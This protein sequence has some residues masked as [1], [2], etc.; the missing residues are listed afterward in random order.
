[1]AVALYARVSTVK[2]AEKDL[3]IPDQLNQMR[4]WCVANGHAV[5]MEYIEAGASATDD[6]RP[7]FQQMIADATADSEP[8]EAVII[9]SR[10]RFFREMFEFLN[11]ERMLKRAG[12]KI[13][14]ITQITSNDPAGEMAAKIFSLF[15]EYQSKE[16]GK[17]TLRAMKENARRGYFNG[18]RPPYGY[19]TIETELMGTKGKKKKRIEIDPAESTTVKRIY[20]LYLNGSEQ[21][22]MGAKD[23]ATYLNNKNLMMRAQKWNRSRVH[24]VLSSSTYKGEYYFNKTDQKTKL[25]KPKSEWIKLEIEPVISAATY[26]DA[27]SRRAARAPA[28]VPPRLVNSPTLLTGLLKCGICGAGLTTATGKGGRYRYYKCNTRIGKGVHLCTMPSFPM[29]KLDDLVLTSLADKVFTADRVQL[30]L[31]EMKKLHKASH[32]DQSQRL[33]PLQKE[34]ESLKLSSER[35]FEAVEKGYL[36]MDETLQQRSHKLQARR[37]DVLLEIA[38]L[39]RQREMPTDLLQPQHIKAF[40]KALRAKLLDRNSRFGKDYLKLLVN[41]IKIEGNEAH[42]SGSYDAL[43]YAIAE[44][45]KGAP[46]RVPTFVSNWLLD[47][48]SNQGH[49]D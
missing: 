15:D 28:I 3:S 49:T 22:S 27:R 5:A 18:S 42:I 32:A 31:D 41:E 7:V 1:M 19:R 21:G 30:M 17:H 13:I 48:G 44:T 40:S 14:S 36:P 34:M 38:S 8:Y 29:Q 45:K 35:L 24:E 4:D 20:E 16:N 37:Q 33:K 46:Q 47:L 25:V 43:A 6:R 39:K 23:I 26:E 12:C 9:H 11:Y 2:Q 10:S